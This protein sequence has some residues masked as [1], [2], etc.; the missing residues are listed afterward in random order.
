MGNES[1]TYYFYLINN[2]TKSKY[3]VEGNFTVE[4]LEKLRNYIDYTQELL[5]SNFLKSSIKFSVSLGSDTGTEFSREIPSEEIMSDFFIKIRPFILKKEPTYF[6]SICNLLSKQFN[7][8]KL[9]III[10]DFRDLYSGVHFQKF[11]KFESNQVILNSEKTLQDWLNAYIY[12]K[13]KIKQQKLEALHDSI[14]PFEMS[15]SLWLLLF[16]DQ[17][18]AILNLSSLISKIRNG[19][20]GYI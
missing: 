10:K 13:D 18:K 15:V 11:V 6:Y 9:N 1:D 19:N 4:E 20:F 16:Q 5:K 14:F 17:A 8:D 3:K 12:H 7:N 2:K